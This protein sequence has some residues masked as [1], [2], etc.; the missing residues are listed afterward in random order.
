MRASQ[1]FASSR[2]CGSEGSSHWCVRPAALLLYR[3]DGTARRMQLP[4][5]Q[6]AHS[7]TADEKRTRGRGIDTRIAISLRTP[8]L[9]NGPRRGVGS[10]GADIGVSAAPQDVP[11]SSPNIGPTQY[12]VQFISSKSKKKHGIPCYNRYHY[13][14]NISIGVYARQSTH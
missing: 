14:P 7:P 11:K 10:R 3:R 12:H 6:L 9:A 13:S 8:A 2:C 4:T 5:C 1:R